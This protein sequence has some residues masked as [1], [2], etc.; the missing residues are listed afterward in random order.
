MAKLYSVFATGGK[1]L[2]IKKEAVPPAGSF[3]D[4]IIRDD[5]AY[6]LGFLKPFEKFQFGANKKCYGH[7]GTGGSFSFA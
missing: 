5:I 3:F 4:E 1:E 7:N 6:S 2:G